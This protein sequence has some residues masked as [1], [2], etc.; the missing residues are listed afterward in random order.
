M[1]KYLDM[2]NEVMGI[3]PDNR[4]R[5]VEFHSPLFGTCFGRIREVKANLYRIT[6]HSVLMTEVSIPGSWII[7]IVD[8]Q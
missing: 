2:A 6:E 8:E 3:R 4:G 1:G 5:F 7:R